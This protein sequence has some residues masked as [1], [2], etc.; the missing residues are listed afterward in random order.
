MSFCLPTCSFEPAIMLVPIIHE[1]RNRQIKD[2]HKHISSIEKQGCLKSL[3]K[4]LLDYEIV[5]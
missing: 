5:S 3:P 4:N 2:L 1:H